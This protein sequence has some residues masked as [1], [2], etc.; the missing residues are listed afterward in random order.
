MKAKL[1]F[2][3]P[4]TPLRDMLSYRNI[5]D[6]NRLIMIQM[7]KVLMGILLKITLIYWLAVD[8]LA[9]ERSES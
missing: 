1:R 8:R 4:H 9:E 3:L 5:P 2:E 7:T 6:L